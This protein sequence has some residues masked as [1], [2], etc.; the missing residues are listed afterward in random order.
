MSESIF[1]DDSE[2]QA[3]DQLVT[4]W[5]DDAPN[6]EPSEVSE[7][8][9]NPE[10]IEEPEGDEVAAEEN[11]EGENQEETP[12]VDEGVEQEKGEE[13]EQEEGEDPQ[14]TL[15]TVLVPVNG[16]DVEVSVDSLKRLYGQE[17]AL[18]QKSQAVADKQKELEAAERQNEA[19]M[20]TLLADV[21]ADYEQYADVDWL[22]IQSRLDTPEF[23]ALREDARQKAERFQ[24]VTEG[25][26]SYLKQ[27]EAALQTQLAEKAGEAHQK[28]LDS[29]IGWSESK[30]GE[31]TAFAENFGFTQEEVVNA[32]SAPLF[33]L[34]NKAFEADKVAQTS[35]VIKQGKTP[36]KIITSKQKPKAI[37]PAKGKNK[38]LEKQ[39]RSSGSED[40]A[41]ALL[42]NKWS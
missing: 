10:V 21:K 13:T 4:T 15:E 31:L 32:V 17:A 26:G 42:L 16:E 41:I 20:E 1:M 29:D 6:K 22:V 24:K 23:E 7:E 9:E 12:E 40:D 25:V 38:A 34:L 30:M 8:G 11:T 36:K 33:L 3:I 27:K 35:K 19:L 14:E 5:E 39:L 37:D 2:A 18:T 28:L